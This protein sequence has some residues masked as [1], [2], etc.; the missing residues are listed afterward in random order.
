MSKF[1]KALHTIGVANLLST[2]VI[3]NTDG[4]ILNGAVVELEEDVAQLIG[5]ESFE[6]VDAPEKEKTMSEETNTP[7]TPA[8]PE[9]PADNTGSETP[10][11]DGQPA[12]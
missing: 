6:E 2:H 5:L 7:E 4:V 8:A 11:T 12:A 10:S 9:A 3:P 1:Y